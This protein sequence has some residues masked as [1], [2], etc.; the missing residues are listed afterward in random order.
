[1]S[2]AKLRHLFICAIA[3]VLSVVFA[4]LSPAPARA[5]EGALALAGLSGDSVVGTASSGYTLYVRDGDTAEF[6]LQ[7]RNDTGSAIEYVNM[8]ACSTYTAQDA[9]VQPF[10][11]PAYRFVNPYA[12]ANYNGA[13]TNATWGQGAELLTNYEGYV[14]GGYTVGAGTTASVIMDFDAGDLPVGTYQYQFT[15]GKKGAQYTANLYSDGARYWEATGQT[16]VADTYLSVPVTV[17]VYAQ[18]GAA[19]SVGVG[20]PLSI[21][22]FSPTEPYDF[23]SFDLSGGGLSG[24]KTVYAVNAGAPTVLTD[25][26]GNTTSIRAT[27]ALDQ[28]TLDTTPFSYEGTHTSASAT[29]AA[30]TSGGGSTTIDSL[31]YVVT[32]DASNYIAG[33]YTGELVVSTVPSSVSVNGG[34]TSATGEYRLPIKMTLT[35]TNPRLDARVS[36]LA[37]T[38]G[39]GMV[40]L[41]WTPAATAEQG[42]YLVFRREGAE[43]QTNPDLIDW[44]KYTQVGSV[45]VAGGSTLVFADGTAR[46]A[47]TYSYTVLTGGPCRG[48]AAKP[49]SATPSAS[50]QTK[51]LAPMSGSSEYVS[52]AS[53]EGGVR[54]FWTMNE[55]YGGTSCDGAGMVD[56]FN[57]YRDGV[58]VRQVYQNAVSWSGS[59]T[60][61]DPYEYEWSTFVPV[62]ELYVD[63]TWKVSAVSPS[64]VEGYRSADAPYGEDRA[65]GVSYERPVVV[66][67]RA[68]YDSR[69]GLALSIDHYTGDNHYGAKLSFW[70]A[71]GTTAPSTSSSPVASVQSETDNYSSYRAPD[72]TDTGV[73]ANK[74]YTYTVRA[75]DYENNESE[76]YTFTVYTKSGRSY[77]TDVSWSVAGGTTPTLKF[78]VPDSGAVARVYR[79]DALVKTYNY[80]GGAYHSY[81]DTP[82][83]DGTY[84]YR[85]D[86]SYATGQVTTT[87]RTYT[88]VRDANAA[89][90]QLKPPDAPVLTGRLSG[91]DVVLTWEA[92]TTGGTA[93]GFY[94]YRKDAGEF[95]QGTYQYQSGWQGNWY[96]GTW[97]CDRYLTM[98]DSAANVLVDTASSRNYNGV[99]ATEGYLVGIRWT[100]DGEA[101]PHEW[102]ICAYNE[103]GVSAP[104]RVVSFSALGVDEHNNPLLPQNSDG[105]VPGVPAIDR[106]WLDWQDESNAQGWDT[107]VGGY[108]RAAWSDPNPGGSIDGWDVAVKGTVYHQQ[109][110]A[111]TTL[112]ASEAYIDQELKQ[113]GI[114]LEGASIN[115]LPQSNSSGDYGRTVEVAVTAHNNAG[116]SGAAHKS[117]VVESLPRF[118]ALAGNGKAVL[119]WTD[120]FNDSDTAVSGW[121]IWRKDPYGVWACIEGPTSFTYAGSSPDYSHAAVDYYEYTDSAL[122]NDYAYEY[123]VI[124]RCEDGTSRSSVVRAVT[125]RRTAATGMP[126]A[127]NNLTATVVN[128]EIVLSWDAPAE[129]EPPQHYAIMRKG[130]TDTHWTGDHDVSGDSTSSVSRQ[131]TA[132][133]YRFVVWSYSYVDGERVPDHPEDYEDPASNPTGSNI[134]EIELTTAQ[135]AEQATA[136]PSSPQITATPGEG[137]VTLSWPACNRATYYTVERI[138]DGYPKMTDATIATIAGQGTYTFVDEDAEPGVRYRYVVTAY[139][140][141]GS[142]YSDVYATP[143][144]TTRDQMAAAQVS[145][146]IAA[147]PD[148]AN[149]TVGD[150]ERVRAVQEAFEALTAVQQAHVPS[151][152]RQKLADDVAAVDELGLLAQYAELVAP[153]QALIDA[154][155][156]A[157]AITLESEQQV[158]AA[159][160]AYDALAPAEAK[161]LVDTTRLVAAEGA[162][163]ALYDQVAADTVI[164]QLEALPTPDELTLEAADAVAAAR[165]AYNALSDNSKAYVPVELTERLEADEAKLVDLRKQAED[166]AAA[167]P[168]IAL[169]EALPEPEALTYADEQALRDARAAYDELGADPKALVDE[170]LVVR[171][172]ADEALLPALKKAHEDEL[173]AQP[174]SAAIDALPAAADLTLEDAGVVSAA[175]QAYDALTDDQKALVG[176]ERA[177]VLMGAETRLQE[178]LNQL[179]QQQA[180][181]A[182]AAVDALIDAIGEVTLEREPAVV[183]A[184]TAY[185]NLSDTARELVTKLGDLEAAEQTLQQL[186]D[187]AAAAAVDELIAALPAPDALTLDDEEGV[188]QVRAAYDALSPQAQAL[189]TR[190]SELGAAE[191]A[192]ASLATERQQARDALE[193]LIDEAEQA[194][195]EIVSSVDGTDV[196]ATKQWAPSAALDAIEG[197]LQAARETA[198]D[199]NART[200]D[201]VSAHESLSGALDWL[202]AAVRKGTAGV[203]KRLAGTNS[204]G[205]MQAIVNEGWSDGKGGYETGGTV[206][207]ATRNGFKD[208]LTAAGIAGLED[209]PVLLTNPKGV[210]TAT[211][212]LLQKMRPTK[213]YV[214]GGTVAVSDATKA[215]LEVAAGLRKGSG[216]RLAGAN[217]IETA[218]RICRAGNGRWQEATAFVARNDDYKDALAIAPYAYA[219]HCP[220]L[221]A[222]NGKS[223]SDSTIKALKDAGVKTVY[224]VGGTAAVTPTVEARLKKAGFKVPGRLAGANSIATSAQVA[225]FALSRGMSAEHMAIATNLNYPDAL[226]GAALCGRKGSVLVLCNDSKSGRSAI[227]RIY[228]PAAASVGR[229]YTFGGTAVVSGTIWN[230]VNGLVP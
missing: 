108:V 87:G 60:Q 59:G 109:E 203:W 50:A 132:G 218:N 27:V 5:S 105:V 162:L 206:V 192:L 96:T 56:H 158:D 99:D 195:R 92:A 219:H 9:E 22:Q 131:K 90:N 49:A 52:V 73:A 171:L 117:I 183:S 4:A 110:A 48:Y 53:N 146:L 40:E 38:A 46:N 226:A 227:D 45:N 83:S 114:E 166:E 113:G 150:V 11:F 24:T 65:R 212:T 140:K 20:S 199:P 54:V 82:T 64:G 115:A 223:L 118:Y 194:Q 34:A 123:K 17:V 164:A 98:K 70:R 127:P 142:V 58:L 139:N 68:E 186:K 205:T 29:L 155:P 215:A 78:H 26:H 210:P 220:I 13:A 159:R 122:M 15:L 154:L 10:H 66:G 170:A 177:A 190:A 130:A 172:E 47:T 214:V 103:A 102:W 18:E 153:V 134:V 138:R 201:L 23:G 163:E 61:D 147:L 44:S 7:V 217:S 229:A 181:E 209:A 14:Y 157:A 112:T 97:G 136:K 41:S 160:A 62:P 101:V 128:G 67:W 174:V 107:I 116:V 31:S 42:T 230:Y 124:A 180:A 111:H 69:D 121:E 126:G 104:S 133:T 143:T 30:K 225:S 120:L 3:T 221:M 129:G 198:A 224:I 141:R 187:A 119:R 152:L 33:T 55:V 182:A 135:V 16:A 208:A 25:A 173:A 19:L 77:A 36:D 76:D 88:F 216:I 95:V 204:F 228:K 75:T 71:E 202:K 179:A 200:A 32:Y 145:T 84:T 21:T 106:L 213:L 207:V 79:N 125:P 197:P 176:E 89:Q 222:G 28:D 43:T 51:L 148:P 196:P 35:G 72:F 211:R 191:E 178:L 80:D 167:A 1:M 100:S 57:V 39:N 193:S 169:L 137:S 168:V 175:R 184:R 161:R 63:Y 85:V 81:T 165:E 94:I 189:V 86:F 74:T 91:E 156:D 185:D 8:T 144:G 2:I 6:T 149:V 93:D 188:A 37:A 151:Y 12:S